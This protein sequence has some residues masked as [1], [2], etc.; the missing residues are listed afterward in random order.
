MAVHK[1][2]PGESVTF[3]AGGDL[4]DGQLVVVTGDREVSA[5][6]AATGVKA[7]GSAATA[8]STGDDV[9]VLLGGVQRLVAASDINAGDLV[10]AADGGKV[11]AIAA[12]TT[13]TAGDVTSTRAILGIALTSVDVSVADDD[14]IEVRLFR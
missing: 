9:L 1:F 10:V 6:A 11:A 3:T 8:A 14:R 7:I 13:P 12:V 5:A 4:T 2:H